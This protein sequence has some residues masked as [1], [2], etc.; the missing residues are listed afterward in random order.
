MFEREGTVYENYAPEFAEN[1]LPSRGDPS[2]KDFVGWTGL[3]PISI[4][5]EYVFGIKPDAENGKIVWDVNLLE[6]HG[7][8]IEEYSKENTACK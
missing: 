1:G 3:V 4:M 8:K 6:K 5:F 2:C 7:I